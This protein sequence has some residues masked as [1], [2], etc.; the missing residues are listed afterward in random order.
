M[1]RYSAAREA[2]R[3]TNELAA[4]DFA[5]I[6]GDIVFVGAEQH[7]Y[8][9]VA[10][11]CASGTSSC[12]AWASATGGMVTSPTVSGGQVYIGSADDELYAFNVL[13]GAQEWTG[14]DGGAIHSP[15][16]Q[17]NGV[18]YVGSD[19][20]KLYA[21]SEASCSS[22]GTS[23]APLWTGATG[24]AI[25]S[26]PAVAN[27]VVYVSSS[28]G[29]LYEFSANGCGSATCSPLGTQTPGNG[30]Y[31]NSSPAVAGGAVYIGALG[32]NPP[33]A[34]DGASV[35]AYSLF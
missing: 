25:D 8:A 18:I 2:R 22:G 5:Q 30:V 11:S 29:K 33:P 4:D 12:L 35:Q 7:L 9:F 21:F 1:F 23:C 13:G 16:A 17:A 32:G 20:G 31:R 14:A 6:P 15:P 27:G 24:G 19:D 26:A 28:D 34:F 3:E 10:N